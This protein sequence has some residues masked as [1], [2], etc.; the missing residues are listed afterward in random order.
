MLMPN[1]KWVRA[2]LV[3]IAEETDLLTWAYDS[4]LEDLDR[5][6]YLCAACRPTG[7]A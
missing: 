4:P 7:D 5:R 6:E 1:D 3:A 2:E